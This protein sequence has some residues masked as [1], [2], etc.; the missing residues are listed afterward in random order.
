MENE[1]SVAQDFTKYPGPR[2]RKSGPYSGEQ[3][4]EDILAPKLREA[5]DRDMVLVVLLDDVAGY[6]SSFLD[7]AFAGLIRAGFTHDELEAHLRIEARTTRFRHHVVRALEY[8]EEEAARSAAL[9]H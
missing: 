4:R 7:E 2:Y 1:I 8:I 5:I 3:F 6:G 9:T